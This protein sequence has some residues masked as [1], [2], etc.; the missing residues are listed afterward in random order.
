MTGRQ[1]ESG[2][3][4]QG[5]NHMLKVLELQPQG[6]REAGTSEVAGGQ[7]SSL[8]MS[9]LEARDSRVI[10]HPCLGAK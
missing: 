2:P 5:H 10:F 6:E 7:S 8:R 1:G 9:L 3:G 4:R